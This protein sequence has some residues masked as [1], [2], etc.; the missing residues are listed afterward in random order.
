MVTAIVLA[1]GGF[2]AIAIV[3]ALLI[4]GEG[5]ALDDTAAAM[6]TIV[7]AH[8]QASDAKIMALVRAQRPIAGVRVLTPFAGGLLPEGGGFRPPQDRPNLTDWPPLNGGPPPA[9]SLGAGPGPPPGAR[10]EAGSLATIIGL[11]G[12]PIWLHRGAIFVVPDHGVVNRFLRLFG[13]TL[14]V[15]CV[16]AAGLGCLVA[17]WLAAQALAPLVRVT[18]EL[19]RF[20]S[21]DFR[22]HSVRSDE[23]GELGALIDAYN[24]AVTQVA[25][26]FTEREQ[27]ELHLR[28]LL[29]EASH[30]M[31]TPLTVISGYLEALE[32]DVGLDPVGRRRALGTLYVETT[33]LRRLVERVTCLARLDATPLEERGP[34]DVLDVLRDTIDQVT[35]ARPGEVSLTADDEYAVVRAQLWELHEAFS[36]LLDNALKYGA[37]S[38]VAVSVAH[39]DDIVCVRVSDSGPGVS[40]ADRPHLFRH[41]FRG[42]SVRELAG[43]GLGLAI[44]ARAAA[45]LGGNI[46]LE[47][48]DPGRRTTFCLTLPA[49]R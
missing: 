11:R 20:A 48:S 16:V 25:A 8:W 5:I 12:Q 2:G 13:G 22:A 23:H 18:S 9:P 17:R 21:G 35:A 36:N 32:K 29:G 3:A 47:E 26:A 33:R 45:R 28:L 46:V 15:I 19:E 40:P 49:F 31:R 1:L 38:P 34:V 39:T 42:A 37:G 24:G 41:F 10:F 7:A 6:R 27:T 44:V 14:V 30:E 4:R 43:T